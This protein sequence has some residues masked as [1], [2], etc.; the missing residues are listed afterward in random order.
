MLPVEKNESGFTLI[1]L[2]TVIV[3]IGILAGFSALGM[4]F[5]RSERVLSATKQLVADIQQARVDALTSRATDTIMGSG[6]RFSPPGTYVSFAWNDNDAPSPDF[7][8]QA[9][10]ESNA[11]THTLPASLSLD[12]PGNAANPVLVYDHSGFPTMYKADG[13]AVPLPADGMSINIID[14]SFNSNIIRC[15]N[16][17]LN[18]VREGVWVSATSTCSAQ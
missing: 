6:I 4:D 1:E 14:P 7:L 15:V 5:V 2:L 9:G 16:V 3:I 12:L 10:E 8:Y 11:Q 18:S 17:T 13:T